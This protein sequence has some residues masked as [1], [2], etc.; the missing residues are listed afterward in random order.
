[1]EKYIVQALSF[2]YIRQRRLMAKDID[3]LRLRILDENIIKTRDIVIGIFPEDLNKRMLGSMALDD[4][5]NPAKPRFYYSV[6]KDGK[7]KGQY[8]INPVN[9]K[10]SGRRA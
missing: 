6:F 3:H 1:M 7:M 4:Y 10:L 5:T 8:W 2:P 9:G